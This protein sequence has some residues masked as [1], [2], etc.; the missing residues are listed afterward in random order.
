M[1][2]LRRATDSGCNG[3]APGASHAVRPFR[4]RRAP[5]RPQAA[6]REGRRQLVD[7]ALIAADMLALVTAF[8]LTEA[9]FGGLGDSSGALSGV[10]E[11]AVFAATLPLWV[12]GA[13]LVRLYGRDAERTDHSTLHE[14]V[15]VLHLA[16]GG[17]WAVF[18]FAWLSSLIEPAAGKLAVF[19]SLALGLV[20]PSR[21]A[22]RAFARRRSTYRVN[23]LILGAG[24]V[25]QL[26]ARKIILHP[27]YGINLVGF[28]DTHPK[29]L[30]RELCH[31]EVLG[32]FDEIT[33]V[34]RRHRVERVVVA[35]SGERPEEV[36]QVVRDLRGLGVWVD[37]VPR[38][39][40]ALGP[41]LGLHAVEGLPLVSLSP[42]R[43]S[44]PALA[45][46]RGLDLV[47][48][49][50]G[51]F[52]TAPLFAVLAVLIK[53]ESPGPV[54]FRQARL[55][56]G[57][58]EFTILKFRTMKVDSHDGP[59]RAYVAQVMDSRA[60]PSANN[61][62]K[63]DRSECVTRVGAWLRKTSLDELPQ[64]WNVLRGDMSLVGPRPCLPYET[65]L[66]E[67]HHFER[68]SV[69]AG[70]TG[71][72]QVTARARST[73]KEALDLD[74]AY[75]RGW[76]LRLDLELLLRTPLSLLRPGTV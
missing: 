7:R 60:S 39:F 10:L 23:T 47:L 61:L 55:G 62:Y 15:S 74:V 13:G 16:T 63:L 20:L 68:F 26:I 1:T 4:G 41:G 73:M 52:A 71:L 42:V 28:V 57:M 45:A 48:A 27:E 44:R 2:K 35:F 76:S 9:L 21:A 54:L 12:V 24:D 40:E 29:E 53:L 75:A 58:R 65:E 30:R 38:L 17:V 56:Q 36:V 66:Y 8:L 51:L 22:A 6:A 32:T 70:I 37:V 67:P 5:H 11:L 49:S 69:P 59:H 46:K 33:D 50:I 14:V 3:R 25:G 34:V 72:W 43:R 64:L 31:L 19:W 18:V